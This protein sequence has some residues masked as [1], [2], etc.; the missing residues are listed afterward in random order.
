MEI[1]LHKSIDIKIKDLHNLKDA[2]DKVDKVLESLRAEI[3]EE[4]EDILT[5]ESEGC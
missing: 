2:E 5:E 3:L 4:V 1:K